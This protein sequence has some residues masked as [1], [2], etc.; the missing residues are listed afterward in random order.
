M[1]NSQLRHSA[2]PSSA[3]RACSAS[4]RRAASELIEFHSIQFI[5]LFRGTAVTWPLATHAQQG[6]PDATY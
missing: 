1:A 3:A 2:T 5:T 4:A 6:E